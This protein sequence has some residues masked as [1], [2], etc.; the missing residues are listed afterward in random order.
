MI[1]LKKIS[2]SCFM[3]VLISVA[4]GLSSGL[5][6]WS[7]E[8]VSRSREV[9]PY[10]IYLL[11]LVGVC[12]LWVYQK[13]ADGFATGNV[14]I[15]AEI[16]QP[17]KYISFLMWPFIFISTLL[18]HWFGAS[19]GR[20][21]TA[22]QMAASATDYICKTFKLDGK[23][24]ALYLIAALSAGFASVFGTVWAGVFFA[25]EFSNFRYTDYKTILS[26]IGTAF[27][28]HY[29]CSLYPIHH[30]YYIMGS[31]P[32]YSFG[33]IFYLAIA[34]LIFGLWARIYI[35]GQ[36]KLQQAVTYIKNPLHRP[37][38]GACLFLL[39]IPFVG[40]QF[41][42]LGLEH[43]QAAF[44]KPLAFSDFFIKTCLTLLCLSV[45]FKGGEVTPLFFIG[46]CLGNALSFIIP[47]PIGF[48][49]AIG[50][51]AVFCGAAKTPLACVFMA[52]ELFEPAIL[53]FAILA[54]FISYWASGQRGIYTD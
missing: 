1:N 10:L 52:A 41:L 43:I 38:V 47:L 7:L 44:G 14:L 45:G 26:I 36:R 9:H 30:S 15:K 28:A 27:G 40:N 50:F 37:F 16:N 54:C 34:A 19:V 29:I 8:A 32:A 46:A 39:I 35:L 18:S 3:L 31:L 33:N 42:G 20:E 25:L 53:G 48:L 24:R 2:F 17:K 5:F 21:G 23:N 51:V 13:Y 6:L 11:P 22:L 4:V 49:A 12:V